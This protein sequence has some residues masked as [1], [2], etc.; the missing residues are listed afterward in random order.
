MN[1]RHWWQRHTD[2]AA[3]LARLTHTVA[4]QAACITQ[5]GVR[6]GALERQIA[7]QAALIERQAVALAEQRAAGIARTTL[8]ERRWLTKLLD[9]VR[10]ED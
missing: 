3:R 8:D 5:Q 2:Q 6:L 4:A 9:N 7:V 1:L 10:V